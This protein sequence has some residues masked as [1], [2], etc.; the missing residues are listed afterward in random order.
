M[1]QCRETHNITEQ[2]FL[3]LHTIYPVWATWENSACRRI[4]RSMHSRAIKFTY[5]YSCSLLFSIKF[6]CCDEG[7]EEQIHFRLLINTSQDIFHNLL[8]DLEGAKMSNIADASLSGA[9]CGT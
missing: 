3:I 2:D 5:R 9:S 6:G 4:D 1:R 8:I 7:S